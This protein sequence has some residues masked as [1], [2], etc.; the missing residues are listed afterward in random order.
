MTSFNGLVG[1]VSNLVSVA[2]YIS[3]LA[4]GPFDP[5]LFTGGRF[6]PNHMTKWLRNLVNVAVYFAPRFAASNE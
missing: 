4:A 3:F 5:L 1:I 6:S 2:L